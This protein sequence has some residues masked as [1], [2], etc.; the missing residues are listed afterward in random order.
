MSTPEPTP[1]VSVD[2]LR[3]LA[4]GWR[5]WAANQCEADRVERV[6]WTTAAGELERLAGLPQPSWREITEQGAP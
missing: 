2:Q 4:L 6:T 5:W 1:S 3:K